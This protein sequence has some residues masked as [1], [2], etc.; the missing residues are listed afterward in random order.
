MTLNVLSHL[1]TSYLL[2]KFSDSLEFS[3]LLQQDV[4]LSCL[5]SPVWVRTAN[6][7][8]VYISPFA[9]RWALSCLH[10]VATLRIA[11]TSNLEDAIH[12]FLLYSMQTMRC[13]RVFLAFSLCILIRQDLNS[14][15]CRVINPRI[16][17][18]FL[19]N[20]MLSKNQMLLKSCYGK[21]LS[22]SDR[23]LLLAVAVKL[24]LSSR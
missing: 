2:M 19:S 21:S 9:D 8:S 20:F 15:D 5:T 14:N 6:S 17:T 1:I 16:N 12:A 3:S 10:D 7:K 18:N 24:L 4:I 11:F 23:I 13:I 22:L